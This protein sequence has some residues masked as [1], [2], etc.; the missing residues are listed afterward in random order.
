[1]AKTKPV[2]ILASDHGGWKLSRSLAAWLSAQGWEVRSLEPARPNQTDDYPIWAARAVRL[3][4]RQPDSRAILSCRSGVGMA[5]V[6]NKFLGIRA[7]QGWSR[8]VARAS[9][10]DEDTNVL[11]LAADHLTLPKAKQI[12]QTWLRT[13]YSQQRRHTRRLHEIARIE[14]AR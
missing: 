14:H 7:V 6:A 10:R 4:Q 3:V 1:M 5:L 8:A 11:S 13:D 9:R 2:L 12:V